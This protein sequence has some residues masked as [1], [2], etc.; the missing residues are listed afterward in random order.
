MTARPFSI[1]DSQGRGGQPP[2]AWRWPARWAAVLGLVV[3]ALSACQQEEQQAPA[4]SADGTPLLRHRYQF[5]ATSKGFEIAKDGKVF[6]P[7]WPL[8]VNFGM[9]LPGHS[10]GEHLATRDQVGRWLATAAELG[11]NAV[12]VNTVQTPA[13][14]QELRK[15]NLYHQDQPLFLLQGAWI[16]EPVEKAE[17]EGTGDY[18]HPLVRAWN[19]DEI[20]KVVDV[21][22]GQRLIAEPS[23]QQPLHYGRAFGLFDADVSPWLLGYVVGRELEPQTVAV[24]LAKHPDP[25]LGTYAG[26]YFGANGG[27]AVEGMLAE[28]MDYLAELEQARYQTQHPIGLE[29]GPKLDPIQHPSEPAPPLSDADAYVLDPRK[30]GPTAKFKAGMFVSYQ[31]APY[32]PDFLMYQPEYAAVAD[33]DGANPLLGY[34]TQLR[35]VHKDVAFLVGGSGVPA[36]LGCGRFSPQGLH[37]G[38]HDEWMQG[39]ADLKIA[40]T[41]VQVGSNGFFLNGIIDEWFRRSAVSD[42]LAPPPSQQHLWFNAVNPAQHFGLIALR[43]GSP[44]DFHAIDGKVGSDWQAKA[45]LLAKSTAPASPLGDGWDDMRQLQSVTVD[46]DAGYLHLLI[47]VKSLDPDG[48]GK[49]EWGKVDYAIALDT[50]DPQRGDSR[51]DPAGHVQVERRV[52]FQIVIHSDTD[53][54]LLVDRPYDL[55]GLAYRVRETWQKYRSVANDAGEF[56]LVRWLSNDRYVWT[57]PATA[58]TPATQVVLAPR[59]VHEVGRLDTGPEDQRTHSSFWFDREQGT[60]ELRIPWALLN[61]ADPSSRLV[62]DDNGSHPTQIA[63]SESAT[64]GVA[65]LA[66]GTTTEGQEHALADALPPPLPAPGST[67]QAKQWWIPA[68]PAYSCKTWQGAPPFH[69]FRKKSFYVLREHLRSVVPA[70][71]QVAP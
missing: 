63:L 27:H 52:E 15:W 71:A 57:K 67:A 4:F 54:Q 23:A 7:F 8:G 19:R 25:K 51:L 62:V 26:A 58:S 34:L 38:G 31:V 64:I 11:A 29:N 21:V 65:V 49:V 20:S 70:S 33:A 2:C 3:A 42:A 18:L 12:Q 10:A 60:L 13:F 6:A 9:A 45:P 53:V 32:A 46:S 5:R 24:T 44:E 1:G 35:A 14:Y 30:V 36:S 17:L 47:A 61:F 69:E 41:A 68:A 16:L 55:F 22:R 37:F 50:V 66:Y 39:W 43:P 56:Q 28:L 48:N 59:W 40:R